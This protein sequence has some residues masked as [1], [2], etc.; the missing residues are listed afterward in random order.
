MRTRLFARYM[1]I[2]LSSF[3]PTMGDTNKKDDTAV[4]KPDCSP[5]ENPDGEHHLL[6]GV[7][8]G[9]SPDVRVVWGSEGE[10]PRIFMSDAARGRSM[11]RTI[12]IRR[13]EYRQ[14]HG[15]DY[16]SPFDSDVGTDQD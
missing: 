2:F 6:A 16:P 13:E 4:P 9:D 10:R 1:S 11:A 12:E 14:K 5:N 8:A 3:F 15:R 7:P